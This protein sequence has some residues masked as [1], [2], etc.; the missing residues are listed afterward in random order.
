MELQ[1]IASLLIVAV[2]AVYLVWNKSGKK[3]HT[4]KA[5]CGDCSQQELRQNGPDTSQKQSI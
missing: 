2:S 3:E 5:E 1:S 4:G